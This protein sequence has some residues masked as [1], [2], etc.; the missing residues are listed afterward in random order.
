MV[1]GALVLGMLVGLGTAVLALF[2]G[3]SFWMALWFYSSVGTGAALLSIGMIYL[4]RT[5]VM[6]GPDEPQS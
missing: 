2:N 5:Y 4:I 6:H 1:I 3:Y